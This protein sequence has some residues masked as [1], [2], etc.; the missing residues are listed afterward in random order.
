M[1]MEDIR[2]GRRTASVE[3]VYPVGA[4]VIQVAGGSEM[5]VGLLLGAPL[6]GT[7]TY[8]TSN[9]VISG[10]GMNLAAGQPPIEL[11]I[12]THGE[13]VNKSWFAIGS[14][15]GLFALISEALLQDK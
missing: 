7:I 2:M 15:A 5:R 3:T 10:Q 11:R 9:A 4:T 8:G 6:T 1:C 13:A 12:E 14:G